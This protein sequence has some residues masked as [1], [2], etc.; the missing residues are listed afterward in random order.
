V[1]RK[2]WL[3]GSICL[4]GKPRGLGITGGEAVEEVKKSKKTVKPRGSAPDRRSPCSSEQNGVRRNDFSPDVTGISMDQLTI[5]A[6]R[7]G[8]HFK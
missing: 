5:E 2:N 4:A 6:V 7:G 1:N 3:Q 8:N